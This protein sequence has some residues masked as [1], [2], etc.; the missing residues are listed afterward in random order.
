LKAHGIFLDISFWPVQDILQWSS[1]FL[2]PGFLPLLPGFLLSMRKP[3][4]LQWEQWN[5]CSQFHGFSPVAFASLACLRAIAILLPWIA[6][7]MRVFEA[8]RTNRRDLVMYSP[9]LAEWKWDV[10]PAER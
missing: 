7:R 9:E 2:L 6:A 3:K 8:Q 5:A 4:A 1:L 10:L